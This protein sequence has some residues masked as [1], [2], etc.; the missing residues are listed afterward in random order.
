MEKTNTHL[1]VHFAIQ[2]KVMIPCDRCSEL[3][4][5]EID[6][7][8][9]II[10]TFDEDMDFEGEEVMYVN[11]NEPYLSL[12]QELYDIINLAIPLRKVPPKHIHLC[13]PRVLAILGLDENGDPIGSQPEQAKEVP[14]EEDEDDIDPR[15]AALKKLKGDD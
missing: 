4:P 11:P 7:T 3:Y 13:D 6:T 15:W 12:M 10:Y 1:D 9:R 14:Q 5:H 8:Y 2:G